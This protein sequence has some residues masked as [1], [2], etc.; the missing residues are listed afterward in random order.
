MS[1]L[2]ATLILRLCHSTR[3][4]HLGRTVELTLLLEAARIHD[5]LTHYTFCSIIGINGKSFNFW[6]QCCLPIRCGAFGF[7]KLEDISPAA[8]LSSWSYTFQQLPLRYPSME[9]YFLSLLSSALT[10]LSVGYHLHDSHQRL[11]CN[12]L[13]ESDFSDLSL[14]DLLANHLKLKK[15]LTLQLVKAK[16]HPC[17]LCLMMTT[18]L[19]T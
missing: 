16:P 11:L 8:F 12:L 17:C 5:S 19:L 7:T 10:N 6:K 9:S 13:E 18:A 14:E 2:N 15:R 3:L 4:N 1:P